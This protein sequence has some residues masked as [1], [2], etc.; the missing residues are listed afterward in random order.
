M[1]AYLNENHKTA[2]RHTMRP[3]VAMLLGVA[4]VS[5]IAHGRSSARAITNAVK[6]AWD[7]V[8]NDLPAK[9]ATAQS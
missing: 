5:I 3:V 7:Q 4:G 1:G 8:R 6:E 2:V 9:L